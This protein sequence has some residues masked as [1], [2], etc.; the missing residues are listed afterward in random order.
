ME[1]IKKFFAN[2]SV[3]YWIA[4]ADAILALVLAVVYTATYKGAIGNNAGGQTPETVG[5]FMFVGFVMQLVVLALP[6]YGFVNILVIAMYGISFYKEVYLIPDFIAGKLNNVEY[7]GGNFGLNMF[8]FIMQLVILVS[9][10]VATFIG[11]YKN[12]ED[13]A[14]D[15]KIKKSGLGI[16]KVCVGL[17]VLVAAGVAGSAITSG[18]Q[19]AEE[20]ALAQALK[21][22]EEKRK[23]EEEKAR[24]EAEKKKFNPITDEVRAKAEQKVY[25]FDPKSVIKKEQTEWDF[26]NSTLTGLADSGTRENHYLVYYFE[27]S[28]AEGYQGDYSRTYAHMYLWDDGLFIGKSN[29]T[30]FRG[31]WYNSSIAE[32]TDEEG[33]DIADCLNM[34]SNTNRYESIITQ[35]CTGFYTKQA[36]LYLGFSWGTRS[37]ICNG[38][39]YYPEIDIAIN[40]GVEND[41]VYKV[42][43]DFS[44]NTLKV[45]RILKDL[46]FGATFDNPK[47]TITIPSGMVVDG[48]LAAAGEYT[49]TA[50]YNGF[51]TSKTITVVA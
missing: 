45:Y 2:K 10:I 42:G 3:G 30:T 44:V 35:D 34:V 14:E 7:N 29:D 46:N 49:I 4:C 19:K 32:G 33:N 40:M 37:I 22:A 5:I 13:E 15:F 48:Q 9:A 21:E 16:G 50:T 20:K 38:F 47:A 12:E 8:Y 1:K 51:E 17:A 28:Y 27:G 18:V 39:M 36:Y 24:I 43:D 11:F 31:Y 25:N 23:E 6:Q 26:S 41:H